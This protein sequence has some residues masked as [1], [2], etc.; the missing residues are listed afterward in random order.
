MTAIKPNLSLYVG[1][2]VSAID[3]K[4]DGEPWEWAIVLDDG[5]EIRNKSRRETFVPQGIIGARIATVSLGLV[6]TT[7]H[8]S[9]GMKWYL[10]PTQ[11]SIVDPAHGGEVYPQWPEELEKQGIPSHPEEGISESPDDEITYGEYLR[12]K[13]QEHDDRILRQ[14]RAFIQEDS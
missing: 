11:Y 12:R 2:Y 13:H 4:E 6:E 5:T 8:F 10:T 3:K 14:G 7:I 9:N 1:L